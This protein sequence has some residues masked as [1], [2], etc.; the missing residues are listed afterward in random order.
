MAAEGRQA[1]VR[2]RP[3]WEL[4]VDGVLVLVGTVEWQ[5]VASCRAR[6]EG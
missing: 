1:E 4:M 5:E 3:P 6:A 2:A